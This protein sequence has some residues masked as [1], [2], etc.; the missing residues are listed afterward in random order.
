M[1]VVNADPRLNAMRA[2][3]DALEE[4]SLNDM[5]TT[6]LLKK[7]QAL[8]DP[9]E[10]PLRILGPDELRVEQDDEIT[11]EE[12][13]KVLSQI[14]RV[15]AGTRLKVT[16]DTF[17]FRPRKN[18]GIL[19]IMVNAAALIVVAAGVALAVLLSRRTEA[20]IIAPSVTILT[21]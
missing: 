21:A 7:A 20:A 6:G 18:G 19:P 15:V 3:A 10:S 1:P 11:P 4:T 14:E 5:R 16:P 13:Q 2:R 17:S 12:R 9:S 8:R